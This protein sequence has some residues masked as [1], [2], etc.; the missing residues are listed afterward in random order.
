MATLMQ[1]PA[2]AVPNDPDAVPTAPAQPG[3]PA[4]E[5][6]APEEQSDGEQPEENKKPEVKPGQPGVTDPNAK[7]EEGDKPTQPGTTQPGTETPKPN[8][9][10]P[11]VTTPRVAPLPVPG[12][13][14]AQPA[15]ANPRQPGTTTPVQ[16]GTTTPGAPGEAEPEQA[17]ATPEDAEN[18]DPM[19]TLTSPETVQPRWEAPV[20]ETAPAAPV[21]EMSGPHTEVGANIDGGGLLPG[22]AANTH[23]FSNLDG[24]VGTIGYSTPGG[25]GDAGISM[26]FIEANTI[27]VTG[28]VGGGEGEDRTVEFTVDTTQVNAAKFATEGWIR[29]QPGGAAA[30][31]ALGDIAKLPVGE[32]PA[33]T[34]D[35]GGVTTE[36]GGSVQ[37]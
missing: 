26:E 1:A 34:V 16:P 24:Y 2:N 25:Y 15:V 14:P 23:H 7:P 6:E 18:T 32:M 22:F 30:L 10:Q 13:S 20:V 21:V 19:D 28:F 4:I 8:P 33:Q 27:K 17:G 31:E 3:E 11:G 9:S 37:Y 29:L 12:Q 35:V 5:N 36:F